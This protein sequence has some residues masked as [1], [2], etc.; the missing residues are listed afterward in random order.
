[1][2]SL[3]GR[4]A[5]QV[6][7]HLDVGLGVAADSSSSSTSQGL[8]MGGCAETLLRETGDRPS[9]VMNLCKSSRFLLAMA[10]QG[11]GCT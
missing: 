2:N 6:L 9:S 10:S 1:M 7:G 5:E 4:L 8:R 3:A 11:K